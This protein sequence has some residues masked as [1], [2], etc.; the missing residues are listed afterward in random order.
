MD[1]FARRELTS[2]D[3]EQ[4]Y[5]DI[6]ADDE[7]ECSSKI[8]DN[9]DRT[10]PFPSD[11]GRPGSA[12]SSRN[13][14]F[15]PSP[16]PVPVRP[17]ELGHPTPVH[18]TAMTLTSPVCH[19]EK[20]H[21]AEAADAKLPH[22]QSPH[23][24]YAGFP[25]PY[26]F[27]YDMPDMWNNNM[28]SVHGLVN[29]FDPAY[30]RMLYRD[31]QQPHAPTPLLPF[32]SLR[33]D[34]TNERMTWATS[35]SSERSSPVG[36][37]VSPP[38]L[39]EELMKK[40]KKRDSKAG[41]FQCDTCKKSYSTINGLTKHK[42]FHCEDMMKKEFSC[43]YCD[44]TYTSLGALKMHIR[45]HTLP[46]KCKLCGKAFS[47]PWLLQGHIR[48]HTGEKPFQCAHCGR[49]FADRSN[50]RAHLQTHSEVKKYRC[51]RCSK[52]FARMSLLVKHEGRECL[53]SI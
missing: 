23:L 27:P 38:V 16:R 25:L 13:S 26:P 48:T 1:S 53:S 42:Q 40:E 36:G 37:G 15:T 35:S 12:G 17:W 39:E 20:H 49:A 30:L 28:K 10:S 22:L 32:P 33:P 7:E 31:H 29:Y 21:P 8:S 51:G 41:H 34:K 45:T 43:K 2:H 14:Q 46:C 4:D 52:T 5:V 6:E 3:E 19:M 11:D 24:R 50:L 18:P 47:R 9:T 44:K